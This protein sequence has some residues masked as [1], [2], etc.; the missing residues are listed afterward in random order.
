M[1]EGSS[2]ANLLSGASNPNAVEQNLDL[3]YRSNCSVTSYLI[4]G[5][6]HGQ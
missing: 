1:E 4:F 6:Q 3:P 5:A 2:V